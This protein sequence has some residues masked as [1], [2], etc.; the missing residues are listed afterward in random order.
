MEFK[1]EKDITVTDKMTS[2]YDK[3]YWDT[4]TPQERFDAIE[5]LRQQYIEY[6]HAPQR[7]QRVLTV[8]KLGKE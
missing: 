5:F 4:K 3:A 8:V 6:T 1:L 2:G 7:L